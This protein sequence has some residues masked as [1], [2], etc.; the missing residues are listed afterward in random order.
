MLFSYFVSPSLQRLRHS[1]MAT[2]NRDASYREWSTITHYSVL[3]CIFDTENR[4]SRDICVD[5]ASITSNFKFQIKEFLPPVCKCYRFLSFSI[6]TPRLRASVFDLK[7]LC[8]LL[9]SALLLWNWPLA[10]QTVPHIITCQG[11]VRDGILKRQRCV[12]WRRETVETSKPEILMAP[13]YSFCRICIC[14]TQ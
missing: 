9:D 6:M 2:K 11:E 14:M 13:F 10:L 4:M 12:W 1:S 7:I 3:F 8:S 5:R